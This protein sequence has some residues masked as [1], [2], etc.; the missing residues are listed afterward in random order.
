MP[1]VDYLVDS[2]PFPLSY[3][4]ADIPGS[5]KSVAILLHSKTHD[6]EKTPES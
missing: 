5:P 4:M 6:V 2:A 3:E 1:I